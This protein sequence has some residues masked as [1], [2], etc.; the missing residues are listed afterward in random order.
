MRTAKRVPSSSSL[1]LHGLASRCSIVRTDEEAWAEFAV[2]ESCCDAWR[3]TEPAEAKQR[4]VS[5]S[6]ER[7]GDDPTQEGALS[8]RRAPTSEVI[9]S[10]ESRGLVAEL[11]RRAAQ[12]RRRF[13]L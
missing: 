4:R 6:G 12:E 2:V 10:E 9:V 8:A 13:K 11:A 3:P 7:C 5:A 1:Y